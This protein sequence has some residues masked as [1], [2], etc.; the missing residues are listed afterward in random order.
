MQQADKP[1]I[2]DLPDC[3]QP[4]AKNL[5][6]DEVDDLLIIFTLIGTLSSV[7][8]HLIDDRSQYRKGVYTQSPITIS[9]IIIADSGSGKSR[10]CKQVF[11]CIN[12]YIDDQVTLY[13]QAM[14]EFKQ[15]LKQ[16]NSVNFTAKSNSFAFEDTLIPDEPVSPNFL[17]EDFTI[18]SLSRTYHIGS[19]HLTI[20]SEEGGNVISARAFSQKSINTTLSFFNKL[21][22]GERSVINTVKDG[23][24]TLSNKRITLLLL[25][26][27]SFFKDFLSRTSMQA[28]AGT[29]QRIFPIRTR[30]KRKIMEN[31]VERHINIDQDDLMRSKN[32]FVDFCKK[33][34]Q[35]DKNGNLMPL[36]I[37]K[38]KGAH[39]LWYDYFGEQND[40]CARNPGDE[41]VS[42]RLRNV[43]TAARYASLFQVGDN[44]FNDK[45]INEEVTRKNMEKAIKICRYGLERQ[46]I[47][48]VKRDPELDKIGRTLMFIQKADRVVSRLELMRNLPRDCR[49]AKTVDNSLL[50][51]IEEGLIE[52]VPDGFKRTEKQM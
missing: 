1:A 10:I 18:E 33:K 3:L 41:S 13:N 27:D 45:L 48:F 39:E 51:L 5:S 50:F 28:C 38:S 17:I 47:E 25:M 2:G 22:C 31:K 4:L 36:L 52:K 12:N 21:M 44:V 29:Y 8:G 9:N 30:N 35:L 24:R 20:F 32:L 40:F 43:E 11:S 49:L 26:Q 19:Q 16:I 15:Q 14:K 23:Q 6:T 37:S 46:I 42:Y 34:P 7:A